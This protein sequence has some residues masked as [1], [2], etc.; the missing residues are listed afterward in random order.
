MN[1]RTTI[2]ALFLLPL[3][4]LF[5][6]NA[7]LSAQQGSLTE[8]LDPNVSLVEGQVAI[9]RLL[10]AADQISGGGLEDNANNSNIVGLPLFY[11]EVA[12]EISSNGSSSRD[13]INKIA[14]SFL[15]NGFRPQDVQSLV[16]SARILLS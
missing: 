11:R 9:D 6:Q 10:A 8:W 13:A 12:N 14:I 7:D 16:A 3:F 15:S 1:S 4:F 5:F 2:K